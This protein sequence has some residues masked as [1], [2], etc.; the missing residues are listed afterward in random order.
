MAIDLNELRDKV[1]RGQTEQVVTTSTGKIRIRGT[2]GPQDRD[3]TRIPK[4]TFHRE[5]RACVARLRDSSDR[6]R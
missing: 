1:K 5:T 6:A 4:Q 3:E 2:S